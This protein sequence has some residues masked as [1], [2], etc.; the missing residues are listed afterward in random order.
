MCQDYISIDRS[1]YGS[2]EI[3]GNNVTTNFMLELEDRYFSVT[4][5]SSEEDKYKGFQMIIICYKTPDGG[6]L[7]VLLFIK[8]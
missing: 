2:T 8:L 3:C 5:R 1:G 4:F 7:N 6:T